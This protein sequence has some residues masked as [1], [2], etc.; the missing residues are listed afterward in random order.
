VQNSQLL[1]IIKLTDLVHSR[2]YLAEK[3]SEITNSLRITKAVFTITQDNA[4]PN[5]TMLNE[6]KAAASFYKDKD[7]DFLEQP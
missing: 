1:N 5:N 4:A 7:R 3:L 6:F 2:D